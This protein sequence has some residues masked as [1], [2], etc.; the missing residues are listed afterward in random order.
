MLT[1]RERIKEIHSKLP[2]QIKDNTKIYIIPDEYLK[3]RY[4]KEFL[5][6]FIILIAIGVLLIF[7]VDFNK[8]PIN[9]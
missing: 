1:Y 9:I 2:S 4:D 7:I 5:I 8:I 6:Y 3:L